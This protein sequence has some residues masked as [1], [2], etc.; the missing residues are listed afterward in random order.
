MIST[1]NIVSNSGG[2]YDTVIVRKAKISY[3]PLQINRAFTFISEVN[4]KLVNQLRSER[5]TPSRTQAGR[6]VRRDRIREID[7]SLYWLVEAFPGMNLEGHIVDGRYEVK[8]RLQSGFYG[9]TWLCTDR[10][11]LADVCLKVRENYHQRIC[12]A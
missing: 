5:V 10:Q 1:H 2:N 11:T 4:S 8:K 12:L 9:V 3:G 6:P 7:L